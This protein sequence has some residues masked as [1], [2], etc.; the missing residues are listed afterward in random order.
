MTK[1]DEN[2]LKLRR[3]FSLESIGEEESWIAS[4]DESDEDDDDVFDEDA[5]YKL[6]RRYSFPLSPRSRATAPDPMFKQT[7]LEIKDANKEF[8]QDN[9]YAECKP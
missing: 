7:I 6:Q 2:K 1:F 9:V 5:D 8:L 3:A 4:G